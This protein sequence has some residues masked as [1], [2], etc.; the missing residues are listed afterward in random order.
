MR[1]SGVGLGQSLPAY[2]SDLCVHWLAV[3]ELN[4]LFAQS[5]GA[6]RF[7]ALRAFPISGSDPAKYMTVRAVSVNDPAKLD[8]GSGKPDDELHAK[9][10][11]LGG[12]G[13]G[14]TADRARLKRKALYLSRTQR[15]TTPASISFHPSSPVLVEFW[16]EYLIPSGP[17]SSPL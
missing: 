11:A 3:G 15:A 4:Q 10:P 2:R 1:H 13:G 12:T 17:T 8:D 9:R 5:R 14:L 6:L 7:T 16:T